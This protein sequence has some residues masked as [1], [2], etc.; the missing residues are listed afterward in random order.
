LIYRLFINDFN[1]IIE[2]LS[3]GYKFH[4]I[5]KTSNQLKGI[6]HGF[7]PHKILNIKI[8]TYDSGLLRQT[9]NKPDQKLLPTLLRAKKLLPQKDPFILLLKVL[10]ELYLVAE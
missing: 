7:V 1:E 4:K 10:L 8:L 5:A 9:I 6:L 2:G 3:H